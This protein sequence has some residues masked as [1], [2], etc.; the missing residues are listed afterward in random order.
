MKNSDNGNSAPNTIKTLE[1]AASGVKRALHGTI[2][3]LILLML[4]F[5][6]GIDKKLIFRLATEMDAAEKFDDVVIG[7]QQLDGTQRYDYIQAKHKQNDQ[8]TIGPGDFLNES[9]GDFSLLK[10]F[11][12]YRKIKTNKEFE[13]REMGDLIIYTNG[14]LEFDETTFLNKTLLETVGDPNQF[15]TI[16]DSGK[17]YRFTLNKDKNHKEQLTTLLGKASVSHQLARAMANILINDKRKCSK[18]SLKSD[19]FKIYHLALG[20]EVIDCENKTIKDDFLKDKT[21]KDELSQLLFLLKDHLRQKLG[22][23]FEEWWKNFERNP[24]VELVDNFGKSIKIKE[25]PSLKNPKETAE[26]FSNCLEQANFTFNS[27]TVKGITGRQL[28]ELAGH[29]IVKHD[30]NPS[31]KK[32]FG[33]YYFSANF[34]AGK[35]LPGNLED[36]RQSLIAKLEK[37]NPSLDL[38][39]CTI[40][41]KDYQTCKDGESSTHSLPTTIPNDQVS[42]DEIND[43]FKH[44]V[45]AVEQP[46]V[47]QLY[48]HI[49]EDIGEDLALINSDFVVN[50]FQRDMLQ[51]LKEKQGRFLTLE[52][53]TGLFDKAQELLA[54]LLITGT[55]L[56][57]EANI[58]SAQIQFENPLNLDPWLNATIPVQCIK[59]QHSTWFTASR[60][61]TSLR[62]KPQYTKKDSFIILKINTAINLYEV[63]MQAINNADLLIIEFNELISDKKLDDFLNNLHE[64]INPEKKIKIWFITSDNIK[65][66][67]LEK[68]FDYR[69]YD[70][71]NLGF[72]GLTQASQQHFLS[73]SI[74]LQGN[75]YTLADL[76]NDND[77]TWLTADILISLTEAKQNK[78]PFLIAPMKEFDQDCYIQRK[79]Q[80]PV[81][82]DSEILNSTISDII[83]LIT[84]KKF[85][86]ELLP[87]EQTLLLSM[88]EFKNTFAKSDNIE[89]QKEMTDKS[90]VLYSTKKDTWSD[91]FENLIVW[92]QNKENVAPKIAKLLLQRNIHIL[93]EKKNI[94]TWK[95]SRGKLGE[96][97]KFQTSDVVSCNESN[98]DENQFSI[99]AAEPGMG[100]STVLSHIIDESIINT[101]KNCLLLRIDLNQY[102]TLINE[103]H[104]IDIDDGISFFTEIYQLSGF[105]YYYLRY[106]LTQ[107]K[108]GAQFLHIY[109]D[110]FD[111]IDA[112]QQEKMCQLFT[113]L[114]RS[115][116]QITVTTRRH[117]TKQLE[118]TLSVV[119]F[120]LKEIAEKEQKTYLRKYWYRQLKKTKHTENIDKNRISKF[121]T[122]IIEEFSNE[123]NDPSNAFMGIPLQLRLIAEGFEQKMREYYQSNSEILIRD[124]V[125][126][127]IELYK[128]IIDNKLNIYINEKII[129]DK[130]LPL[131]LQTTMKIALLTAHAQLA[132]R[133]VFPDAPLPTDVSQPKFSSNDFNAIGLVE[134]REN[135]MQFVHRTFGEYLIAYQLTQILMQYD[136][137]SVQ[138]KSTAKFILCY[139][140]LDNSAVILKFLSSMIEQCDNPSLLARWENILRC[141]MQISGNKTCNQN[142]YLSYR[143][144]FY[145]LQSAQSTNISK[146]NEEEKDF[147][148]LLNKEKE[149]ISP[150]V[151]G[152]V[153]GYRKVEEAIVKYLQFAKKYISHLTLTQMSSILDD[154]YQVLS[155]HQWGEI[156]KTAIFERL[157]ALGF[158][159]IDKVFFLERKSDLFDM[160]KLERFSRVI[161]QKSVCSSHVDPEITASAFSDFKE[162]L[163]DLKEISELGKSSNI[164][165]LFAKLAGDKKSGKKPSRAALIYLYMKFKS[166]ERMLNKA[167]LDS[168]LEIYHNFESD[169][170]YRKFILIV[171]D[172]EQMLFKLLIKFAEKGNIDLQTSLKRK[173][174]TY[175]YQFVFE[176][177]SSFWS[178]LTEA[179]LYFIM[180]SSNVLT[181]KQV[182]FLLKN[183]ES[184]SIKDSTYYHGTLTKIEIADIKHVKSCAIQ[185]SNFGLLLALRKAFPQHCK[186]ESTD[187]SKIYSRKDLYWLEEKGIELVFKFGLLS[188][189]ISRFFMAIIDRESVF[190]SHKIYA[191]NV[192][193]NL[194]IPLLTDHSFIKDDMFAFAK[195]AVEFFHFNLNRKIDLPISLHYQKVIGLFDFF[196]EMF[197]RYY[198][199]KLV[200]NTIAINFKYFVRRLN[201]M[202]SIF[203]NSL[204]LIDTGG[205]FQYEMRF[206]NSSDTIP[207]IQKVFEKFNVNLMGLNACAKHLSAVKAAKM[208]V[209]RLREE[210]LIE[211]AK[212]ITDV[213]RNTTIEYTQSIIAKRLHDAIQ[214]QRK[215]EQKE[216]HFDPGKNCYFFFKKPESP[217]DNP[218]P[219]KTY[220]PSRVITK[221]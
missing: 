136:E 15:I 143:S 99:I 153:R 73:M 132:H 148:T 181:R 44:L 131:T 17:F 64:G 202:I 159:Y 130:S 145:I 172:D 158:A 167:Q 155:N 8:S 22:K 76:C 152:T 163:Q 134:S 208:D 199:D 40:C 187:I 141:Q 210:R 177:K 81:T 138:Y 78:D 157:P 213:E 165:D 127:P 125:F 188:K 129:L 220:L 45:L 128:N 126:N 119:S 179:K 176:I 111:E 194:I 10:Y 123:L 51:W 88:S 36:F 115:Y 42:N 84:G 94:L 186:L 117:K 184:N 162:Q 168:L 211:L 27:K 164:K 46:N 212:G 196:T 102:K 1:Y 35:N 121:T 207:L 133:I 41:I 31:S 20:N 43:F 103:S 137:T 195:L 124:L 204:L 190:T 48:E 100:K 174:P 58:K 26:A 50:Q 2:Y 62:E 95:K 57:Y 5:K 142:I 21:N 67:I 71:D 140:F 118:D 80:R 108:S 104:F 75:T 66:Q 3:Q 96:L 77:Y 180:H 189:E 175:S 29:V 166:E 34:I 97:R 7:W 11:T 83:L 200:L 139:A 201:L 32:E 171:P 151:E 114:Q 53:Q 101:E 146:I 192:L 86:T 147:N 183:I 33:N 55:I 135:E 56:E 23:D 28:E 217:I 70:D 89:E 72:S 214:L 98:F 197:N 120:R 91:E 38:S 215:K 4:V 110:G 205:D 154:T 193:N 30:D 85:I 74:T 169:L 39:S 221:Y 112:E 178:P 144:D 216:V 14:G 63:M 160:E 92:L 109:F 105:N 206:Q 93:L 149:A 218:D 203:E 209:E 219:S 6:R 161:P 60:I 49:K 18:F 52:D 116:L 198:Y 59:S 170:F 87:P 122:A 107:C 54:R 156:V 182:D 69:N 13:N 24:K 19:V 68:Y 12:S 9:D 25:N 16:N 191:R 113:L 173:F 106:L 65:L 61:L 150:Y 47:D 37:N 185:Y 82:I 79:F 90:I